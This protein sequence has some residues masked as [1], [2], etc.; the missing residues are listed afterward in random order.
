[1]VIGFVFSSNAT[2]AF[3]TRGTLIRIKML[4]FPRAGLGREFSSL[5]ARAEL[6][7]IGGSLT[8]IKVFEAR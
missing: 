8:E 6:E 2:L 7:R 1:M 3:V 5:A 4:H